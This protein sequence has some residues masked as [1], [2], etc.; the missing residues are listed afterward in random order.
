MTAHPNWLDREAYPF[1][2]RYFETEHGRI[3]YV[4]EGAG[5]PIVM[6]HGNP[7]WS[8]IYRKF[9]KALSGTYRCIALD[10]LGFGLSDKPVDLAYT[11]TLHARNVEALITHLNLGDNIILMVQDWGGPTGLSY[12]FNHPGKVRQVIL[13]NTWAWPVNGDPHFERFSGMMAS[14]FGRFLNLRLNFFVRVIMRLATADR[15]AMPASVM[16]QYK[17]PLARPEDRHACAAFPAQITQASAFLDTLW[18][19]REN[20]AH[21]PFLIL[22]GGKDIAFRS[23][24]LDQWRSTLQQYE[25][26]Y[27]P[28]TGHYVQE[29]KFEESLPVIKDFLHRYDRS[30]SIAS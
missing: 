24:E 27:F 17:A 25:L 8:F 21:I 14:R 13:F 15:R 7:T 9:I 4:D 6:V 20:I 26:T 12:A 1:A 29:E 23:E 2:S 28:N 5:Q 22:W 3:H 10:H 16:R 11:P 18:R 19:K 30:L